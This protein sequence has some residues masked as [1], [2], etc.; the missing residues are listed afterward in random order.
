VALVYFIVKETINNNNLTGLLK[1]KLTVNRS[2]LKDTFIFKFFDNYRL[3]LDLNT[4][5]N[6]VIQSWD[7]Q[8]INS[9]GEKGNEFIDSCLCPTLDERKVNFTPEPAEKFVMVSI[10][11]FSGFF[12]DF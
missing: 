11:Y 3:K 9:S 12:E 10:D 2:V 1:D 5:G 6:Q 7:L 8:F 4:F